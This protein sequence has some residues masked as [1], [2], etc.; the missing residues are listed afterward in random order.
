MQKKGA[1]IERPLIFVMVIPLDP[2]LLTRTCLL[3]RLLD[4]FDFGFDEIAQLIY[5]H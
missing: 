4:S 1:R 2:C 3:L 5:F